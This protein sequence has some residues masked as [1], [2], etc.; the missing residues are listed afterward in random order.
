VEIVT[1]Y[2]T[3]ANNDLVTVQVVT[4][5]HRSTPR[6]LGTKK[7]VMVCR[8]IIK[9]AMGARHSM[10][11]FYFFEGLGRCVAKPK[12]AGRYAANRKM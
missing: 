2:R 10:V 1:R 5:T 8:S 11:S 3:V 6:A 9:F 4:L 7:V 12:I